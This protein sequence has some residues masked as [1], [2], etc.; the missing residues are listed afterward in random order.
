MKVHKGL[1]WAVAVVLLLG[2]AGLFETPA[3]HPRH[4]MINEFVASNTSGLVD[5]DGEAADWIELYNGDR[6]PVNLA[7]WSL[8]DDPNNPEK[9]VFPDRSLEAGAYLVVFAS[10]KD[11][12]PLTGEKPLHAS[13]RLDKNG[14][15]LG[16]YNIFEERWIDTLTPA[17]PEQFPD[18]AYGRAEG[19]GE[20]LYLLQPTPGGPNNNETAWAG[21]VERVDFGGKQ[22]GFYETPFAV[23]LKTTTPGATIFYTLDGSEP[24]E[25]NGLKY[26][27]PIEIHQTTMLRAVAVKPCLLPGP[28]ETHTYIFLDDVLRQTTPPLG[29]PPFD[30]D[31]DPRVVHDPRYEKTIKD[32]LRSIPSLSIV[33]AVSNFD[34]YSHPRERGE[35]WERPVSVELIDPQ[36]HGGFQIN[37]GL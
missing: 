19:Q 35:A 2:T 17:Y 14:G 7:G 26:D 32:D 4:L 11:R 23:E 21:M 20:F 25:T 22:R 30:F 6:R 15:F 1:L 33:T 3:Q 37:A 28:V 24:A 31:M 36:G 8:S 27:Q 29:L 9:W 34:I 5:E 10:G 16:L 12:K 18:M 13:F